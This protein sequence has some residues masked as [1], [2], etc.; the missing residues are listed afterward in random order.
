MRCVSWS[1][2]AALLRVLGSGLRLLTL[3]EDLESLPALEG[4]LCRVDLEAALARPG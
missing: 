3:D 2:Y 4:P 1:V